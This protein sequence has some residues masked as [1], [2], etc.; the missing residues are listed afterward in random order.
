[1]QKGD[2][3]P[4]LLDAAQTLAADSLAQGL[5]RRKH[6][7]DSVFNTSL[8]LQTINMGWVCL[9]CFPGKKKQP[10]KIKVSEELFSLPEPF[11]SC[12]S[13]CWYQ[14]S[15][16]RGS[17]WRRETKI[18]S[19]WT[20]WTV[21]RLIQ[22]EADWAAVSLRG[23]VTECL[24]ASPHPPTIRCAQEWLFLALVYSVLCWF[25]SN[26][27]DMTFNEPHLACESA[28]LKGGV[29]KGAGESWSPDLKEQH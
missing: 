25:A 11:V 10:K 23:S 21:Y 1:M 26:F 16:A 2:F 15:F 20:Q 27:V 22:Q 6:S 17:R 29:Q 9:H 14:W 13:V 7:D 5:R 12:L 24:P 4:C 8:P 19:T 3:D 28:A 18:K